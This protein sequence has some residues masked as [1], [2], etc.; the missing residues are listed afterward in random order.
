MLHV[1]PS[2]VEPRVVLLPWQMMSEGVPVT[3]DGNAFTVMVAEI[4]QPAPNE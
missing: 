1:P 4:E 2:G 3:V